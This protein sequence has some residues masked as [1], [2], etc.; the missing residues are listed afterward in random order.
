MIFAKADVASFQ[1]RETVTPEL[2]HLVILKKLPAQLEPQE[3]A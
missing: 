3:P 2:I 1:I